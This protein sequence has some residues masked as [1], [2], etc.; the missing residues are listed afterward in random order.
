VSVELRAWTAGD[1]DDV[2]A[3]C[4]DPLIQ[5]F[6]PLLP[7]PYTRDDALSFITSRDEWQFAITDPGSSRLLGAVGLTPRTPGN[8]EVGYWVAPW[9]RGRG[10]ATAAVVTLCE[11]AFHRQFLRLYLRTALDN[12]VSQ[13]VAI[14]AGFQR[15]GIARGDGPTRDGGREDIV[16]W[17]RLPGDPPGPARRH[18]PDLPDGRLTDGVVTLRR[19]SPDDAAAMLA[20]RARPEVRERS[21]APPPSPATIEAMCANADARW[22]AGERAD[23]TI[24]DAATDAFAGDLGFYY[25]NPTLQQGMVGYSLMPTYR[26]RGYASRAVRLVSAWAFEQVGLVRLTAGTAPDNLASQRVLEAA[27]FTREAYQRDLLP[28]PHGTR[29]DNINYVLRRDERRR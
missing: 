3:A 29:V 12:G 4:N 13:R 15:E 23:M 24:R 9:A 27:G 7:R 20:L 2:T 19:V 6:L 26:G 17:S 1:A 28:G 16:V 21:A 5:R 22:L 10:V 8:G 11:R 18:L 14:G 25:D